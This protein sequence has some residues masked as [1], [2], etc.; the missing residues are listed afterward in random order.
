MRAKSISAPVNRI[1][2]GKDGDELIL[3]L[4]GGSKKQLAEDIEAVISGWKDYKRR[5]RLELNQ[6]HL[7]ENFGQYCLIERDG[8]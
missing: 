7:R 8:T 6:G 5:K 2:F 1:Y 3:L 4:G